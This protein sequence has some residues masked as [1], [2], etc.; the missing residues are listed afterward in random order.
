MRQT[1]QTF[2]SILNRIRKNRQ[3]EIDIAWLK[4]QCNRQAPND[5]MF[6]YL[7]FRN[8]GI[9]EHK[10]ISLIN[11]DP[12]ILEA[13]DNHVDIL[14]HNAN[15]DEKHLLAEIILL[16]KGILVDLIGE[17]FSIQDVL[18]NG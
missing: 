18:I 4:K 14:D 9:D 10:M 7:F 2:I 15:N 5:P 6:P 3:T 16:K 17:N 8:K 1:D 13:I 11:I 12:C